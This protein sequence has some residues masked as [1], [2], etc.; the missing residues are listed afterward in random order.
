MD[1]SP[2]TLLQI[3]PEGGG[4]GVAETGVVFLELVSPSA[5]APLCNCCRKVLAPRTNPTFC[6]LLSSHRALEKSLS[7]RQDLSNQEIFRFAM[8]CP[9][10]F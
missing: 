8:S 1:W 2:H 5:P 6:Y 7:G 3:P 4:L 9:M 10:K